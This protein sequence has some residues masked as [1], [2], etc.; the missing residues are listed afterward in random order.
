VHIGFNGMF[1]RDGSVSQLGY[2][3]RLRFNAAKASS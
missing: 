2:V 1:V 3:A